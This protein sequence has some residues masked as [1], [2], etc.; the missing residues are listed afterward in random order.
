MDFG[1]HFAKKSFVAL[2]DELVRYYKVVIILALCG[3]L[4]GGGLYLYSIYRAGVEQRA[5]QAFVSSMKYF[6]AT[7]GEKQESGDIFD[8]EKISFTSKEEKWKKVADV[9]QKGYLEHKNSGIAPIF[10]AFQSQAL[11]H[12]NKR[13]EAIDLLDKA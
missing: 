9:F 2:F 1:K 10:L 4:T 5:H 3:L 12:Q 11:I 13:A 6:D 7:V 8:I